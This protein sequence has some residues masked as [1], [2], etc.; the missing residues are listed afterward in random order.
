MDRVWEEWAEAELVP[1]VT[2]SVMRA[3][4]VSSMCRVSP[5]TRKNV[6]NVDR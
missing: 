6:Q 5:A 1:V 3:A 2:V 4:T